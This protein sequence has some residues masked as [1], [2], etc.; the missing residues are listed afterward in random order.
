[1]VSRPPSKLQSQP[2]VSPRPQQA[3]PQKKKTAEEEPYSGYFDS[4]FAKKK[5]QQKQD[6]VDEDAIGDLQEQSYFQ[7]AH[8]EHP[9]AFYPYDSYAS[10][11]REM[12]H[13]EQDAEADRKHS[14]LWKA[15]PESHEQDYGWNSKVDH[16]WVLSTAPAENEYLALFGAS[17]LFA[18]LGETEPRPRSKRSD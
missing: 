1:M 13:E 2:K 11:Y 12:Y 5:P 8:P 7:E 18:Q 3:A 4:M 9:G 14:H 15:L 10:Y 17:E 16:N 6:E